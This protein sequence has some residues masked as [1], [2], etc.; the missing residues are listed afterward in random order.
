[1]KMTIEGLGF[2]NSLFESLGIPYEFMQWNSPNVPNTYWVGEYIETETVNEDGLEQASFIL[3]G[4]TNQKFLELE[5][6]KQQLKDRIGNEG[7]TAILESGS[8]IVISFVDSQ[9]LPSVENG[10]HRLQ[11]TLNVREWRT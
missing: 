9:P 3:T 11:I 4:T 7:M 6:V 2:V 8:A 10:V 1:M 5:T